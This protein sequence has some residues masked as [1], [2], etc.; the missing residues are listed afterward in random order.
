MVVGLRFVLFCAVCLTACFLTALAQ[1]ECGPETSSTIAAR[2]WPTTGLASR[3]VSCG[4]Q[5]CQTLRTTLPRCPPSRQLRAIRTP[6]R[7]SRLLLQLATQVAASLLSPCLL[8]WSAR[9][10]LLLRRHLLL[11]VALLPWQRG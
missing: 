8:C 1:A 6:P 7:V 5:T 3:A 2:S 11:H 10:S 9:A 4:E